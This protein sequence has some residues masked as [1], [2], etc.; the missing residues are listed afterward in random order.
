MTRRR[1]ATLSDCGEFGFLSRLLPLLRGGAGILVGPGDDCAVV[2]V[3]GRRLLLTTDSLVEGVHFRRTWMTARQIGR[4][5]YLVN[6]SDIAAMGGR[7]RFCLVS[8]GA[9]PDFPVRDLREIHRG[10]EGAAWETGARVAG[11]N[12]T[13]ARELLISVTLIGQ[14][15]PRPLL[16]RGARPGDLLFVTGALG[17][18]ALGLQ[19]LQRD[20]RA[21]GPTVRRFRE[22]PCR[23]AAG[24]VLARTGVAAA[25]VDVSDGL[26]QDLGHLCAASGVGARIEL[27][28]IPCARE[29]L[30]HGGP[31]A[32]QGGEDYELLCA[33]PP[34]NLR[35]VERVRARLRCDFT[36][37]GQ[38]MPQR[39]RIRVVDA[40]GR[41]V[42]LPATG[43]DHFGGRSRP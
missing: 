14:A 42:N 31:L 13:R 16:R 34:R 7:P 29:V 25:A 2:S 33:V 27:A 18:A 10:I 38:V 40:A 37:I 20:A 17:A 8:V 19:H 28:R 9:P 1:H 22:P 39:Y 6:A 3:G 43:F 26:L 24:A 12:L 23:L 30:R 36:Q 32:L 11:G 4:K 5:A 21:R 15:P 35:R 41:V